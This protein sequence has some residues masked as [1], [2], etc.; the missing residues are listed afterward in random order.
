MYLCRTKMM[1]RSL[2]NYVGLVQKVVRVGGSGV[3]IQKFGQRPMPKSPKIKFLI[4]SRFI[5]NK[6]LKELFT[7]TINLTVD[8]SERFE[9]HVAGDFDLSK[10]SKK[11]RKLVNHCTNLKQVSFIGRINEM[12]SKIAEY[13]AVVLPS[14]REGLSKFLLEAAS[15]G[16]PLLAS[17]VPGCRELVEHGVNGYIFKSKDVH[18]LQKYMEKFINLDS[19]RKEAMGQE[20]RSLIEKKYSEK[21]I[22]HKYIEVLN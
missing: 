9:L 5:D 14:Y 8:Y 13:D 7:A 21:K 22:T 3:D 19:P 16:R 15:V 18:D 4:A 12:P 2:K 10:A 17:D 20:S 11:L 6:G 1:S